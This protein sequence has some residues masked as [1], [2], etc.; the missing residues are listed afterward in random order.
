M[1]NDKCRLSKGEGLGLSVFLKEGNDIFH[2]YSTYARALDILLVT[3]RILDITLL[4]RQDENE[5]RLHDEYEGQGKTEA[6]SYVSFVI[7]DAMR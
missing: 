2:T 7:I 5:W 1:A 4:G 3:H 6:C